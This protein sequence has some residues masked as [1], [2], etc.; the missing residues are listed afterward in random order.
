MFHWISY[1]SFEGSSPS[2]ASIL[3]LTMSHWLMYYLLA[4]TWIFDSVVAQDGS[5]T[6]ISS[7]LL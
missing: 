2:S 6:H 4:L 7:S 1:K 3:T 5:T